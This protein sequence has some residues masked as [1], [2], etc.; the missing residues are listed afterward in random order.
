VGPYSLNPDPEFHVNPD[1]E[2]SVN[3]DP[4]F[5]DQKLKKKKQKKF[6]S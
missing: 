6:Y 2:L 3:P 4:G 1:P 5:G